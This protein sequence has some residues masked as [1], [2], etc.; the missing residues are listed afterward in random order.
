MSVFKNKQFKVL[1]LI[2]MK[3]CEST[4]ASCLSHFQGEILEYIR[5][6]LVID[7]LSTDNSLDVANSSLASM[8]TVK[9][10]MLQN[11][12]NYG[13]G[14]THKM[15]FK[16]AY[17]NGYDFMLVVH[18]DDSVDVQEFVPVFKNDDLLNY[19]MILSSRL[20]GASQRNNYSTLRFLGN[21][22]LSA[23]ASAITLSR[24]ADFTGGGVN[25]YRVSRFFNKYENPIKN[26]SNDVSFAQYL[27]LYACYRQS[28]FKF[29]PISH[30]EKDKKSLAQ[31]INQF[32]KALILLAKYRLRPTQT[33]SLNTYGSYFG[34]TFKKIKISEA[35]ITF[36]PVPKKL[37]KLNSSQLTDQ[38]QVFDLKKFGDD[39]PYLKN[40]QTVDSESFDLIND[41]DPSFLWI[42]LDLDFTN[43]TTRGLKSFFLG[44]FK[45]YPPHKIRL[46]IQ[47]E[48]V[49]GSKQLIEFFDFCK[50]FDLDYRLETFGSG[51]KYLWRHH[52]DQIKKITLTFDQDMMEREDFSAVIDELN[53][54]SE[55]RINVLSH[56]EKFYFTYGLFKTLQSRPNIYS[57]NFQPY[58]AP[59][60]FPL[61]HAEI[62]QDQ[63]LQEADLP[64]GQEY[65]K[66]IRILSDGNV[67]LLNEASRIP[68]GSIFEGFRGLH[69]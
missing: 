66:R 25:L 14:G 45:V 35:G 21:K 46:D 47:A 41:T 62:L 12:R 55:L 31:M 34:H 32:G 11:T 33:I 56:P 17:D 26:F 69:D 30:K 63:K 6:I 53:A 57:I 1:C 8:T 37:N 61:D 64:V 50:D 52:K 54:N 16:Y 2:P 40:F 15:G 13:L 23:L 59:G 20:S 58:D 51:G 48:E 22:I 65:I 18:G 7:N 10:T 4:I 67:E 43:I 38:F 27:I 60:G 68:M 29:L 24:V 42:S 5:E 39:D 49:L 3:N 28:R 44:L 19:E 9:T 36:A